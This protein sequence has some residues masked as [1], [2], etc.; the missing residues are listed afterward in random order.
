MP[1]TCFELTEIG[2]L[3]GSKDGSSAFSIDSYFSRLLEIASCEGSCVI[4]KGEMHYLLKE[5][6]AYIEIRRGLASSSI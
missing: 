5:G 2:A 4:D 3:S 1:R 6:G